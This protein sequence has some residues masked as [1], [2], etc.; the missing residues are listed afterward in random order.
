LL[1]TLQQGAKNNNFSRQ[2]GL[3]LWGSLLDKADVQV[4]ISGHQHSYRFSE[5]G[6]GRHWAQLVGGGPSGEGDSRGSP[7]VIHGYADAN[8]LV[9]TVHNV[10]NDTV[11]GTFEFQPRKV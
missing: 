4:V 5:P 7:T 9:I 11:R 2:L 10:A 1:K 3:K 6:E 8:K